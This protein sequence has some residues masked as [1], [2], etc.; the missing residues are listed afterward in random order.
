LDRLLMKYQGKIKSMQKQPKSLFKKMRD[1]EFEYL[2]KR[3]DFLEKLLDE[4]TDCVERAKSIFLKN[5]YHEIR[6][7]LNAI[8]GFS[9]LIEMNS[10]PDREKEGYITHIRESSKDFLRKM[11][12]IIEASIIEAGLL[13]LSNDECKIYDLLSEIHSYFSVQKHIAEKKIAL[14]LSVPDE[15]KEICI[16]CDSYR[17]TQVFSN[18]ISNAFKFTQQGIV[19]FGCGIK[20]KEIEFFVRDSG[21]GGLE[22]REKT[23]YKNFSKI[24][25]SDESKEG[26]GLGLSLSKKLVELMKGKIWYKSVRS[27]GTIFYFTIPFVRITKT[28]LISTTK[29]QAKLNNLKRSFRRSV[30][31]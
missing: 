29:A 28:K 12:D 10:V 22:G 4:K 14:L 9:E 19:E 5:L 25:E 8:V 16:Q 15:L 3:V 26:L 24:D 18:L 7:P 21:I 30:A 17:L 31:L 20:N 2:K 23:V 27:Q 13:R 11:D 6:T 1:T